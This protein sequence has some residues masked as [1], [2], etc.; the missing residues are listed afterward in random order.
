MFKAELDLS[1]HFDCMPDL[2]LMPFLLF[3]NKDWFYR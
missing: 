2:V 1:K 3:A